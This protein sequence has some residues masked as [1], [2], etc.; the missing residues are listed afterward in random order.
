MNIDKSK[1]S[2]IDQSG[3]KAIFT[4]KHEQSNELLPNILERTFIS[5]FIFITNFF[6]TFIMSVFQPRTLLTLILF[7]SS[8]C[9]KVIS[10]P[11]YSG[12]KASSFRFRGTTA[13]LRNDNICLQEM[14]N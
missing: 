8:G 12:R 9:N 4:R 3:V 13:S 1:Q 2:R 7:K 10:K 14:H 11:A 6:H 5:I